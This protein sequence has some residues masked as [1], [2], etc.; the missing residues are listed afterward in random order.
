MDQNWRMRNRLPRRDCVR[1]DKP[2][3]IYNWIERRSKEAIAS[4]IADPGLD[5][6]VRSMLVNYRANIAHRIANHLTQQYEL[7]EL[8]DIVEWKQRRVRR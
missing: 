2:Y 7:L 8:F 1:R 3:L 5:T 6:A 4:I